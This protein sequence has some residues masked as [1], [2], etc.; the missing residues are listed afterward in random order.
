VSG[1]GGLLEGQVE[2]VDVVTGLPAG[3]AVLGGAVS[4]GGTTLVFRA[5]ISAGPA[6]FLPM[7]IRG[8]L[9]QTFVDVGG[10]G[11]LGLALAPS[12]VGIAPLV[13][14]PGAALLAARGRV[15]GRSRAGT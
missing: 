14:E 13:P 2:L 4:P 12:D 3:G 11:R 10:F 1:F 7:G 8:A 6:T 5:S 9:S 15:S